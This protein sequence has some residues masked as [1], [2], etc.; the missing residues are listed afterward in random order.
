[1]LSFVFMHHISAEEG[2]KGW[3][4]VAG[5]ELIF[6]STCFVSVLKHWVAKGVSKVSARATVLDFIR[7]LSPNSESRKD[8]VVSP[9]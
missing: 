3:P 1:M 9:K 8:Q 6:P 7:C 2:E 4:G 5:G